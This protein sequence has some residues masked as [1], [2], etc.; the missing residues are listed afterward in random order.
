M[1]GRAFFL[2]WLSRSL[3]GSLG[4]GAVATASLAL[5]AA[6]VFALAT[7]S[8]GVRAQLGRELVAYGANLLVLPRSA[9]LRFGLGSLELGPVE[10]ERSLAEADLLRLPA[11]PGSPVEAVAP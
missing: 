3:R 1:T 10:E 8:T 5:S 6:L 9:P 11:L 4:S 2:R 7:V